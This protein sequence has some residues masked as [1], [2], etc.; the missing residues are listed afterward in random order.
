MKALSRVFVLL[1]V[2]LDA[3]HAAVAAASAA[4]EIRRVVEDYI[5]GWREGD[6]E[7]LSRV[8]ELDH[9]YV[10]WVTTDE[11]GASTVDSMT[12][13]DIV[14]RGKAAGPAYGSRVEILA[15]DVTDDAVATAELEIA[16][17]GGTYVD[18]LTLYRV[19]DAW[20]IVTKAFATRR[21]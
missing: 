10:I 19:G 11:A 18:H 21:D 3:G 5:V 2:S 16:F 12:F 7:I 9:G 6:S 14:A 15:I 1:L 17:A 20:K 4:D 8:F 13:R